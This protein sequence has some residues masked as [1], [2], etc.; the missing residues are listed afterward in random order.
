MN[1][2]LIL[3]PFSLPVIISFSCQMPKTRLALVLIILY[4]NATTNIS[5]VPDAAKYLGQNMLF[6]Y[7]NCKC[8]LKIKPIV[9]ID[10][11][12]KSLKAAEI[13]D[14]TSWYPSCKV[15]SGTRFHDDSK[16][17]RLKKSRTHHGGACQ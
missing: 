14:I 4:I 5:K 13:R 10:H 12:S 16:E 1:S 15:N 17:T 8:Y 3:F 11:P 6:I 7:D 9:S 2:E